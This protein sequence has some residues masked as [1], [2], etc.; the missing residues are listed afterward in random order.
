MKRF[1]FGAKNGI[2]IVDL[3]KTAQGLT[4]A[5]E[6]LKSVAAQGGAI[7][8]VGTKR[9]AQS[10]IAEEAVRCGHYYV[11]LRWLGG[12]LT[13][14]QT[15]RKSIERLKQI[16]AW[17]TDGTMEKLTKK[18]VSGL[19]KELAKLERAFQGIVLM[20]R[21]PKAIY[22]VDAK[23]EETAIQEANRLGIP[24]VALVDTNS[25]PDPIH[26]VIPGN[27]DAIRSIKLVTR[28]LADSIAEG[29]QAYLAGLE[30][31]A[32]K[33]RAA[34]EAKEAAQA[35]E[36]AAAAA[37]VPAEPAALPEPILDDVEAIIPDATLKTK[38]DVV[39]EAS[40]KKKAPKAKSS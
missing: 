30:A 3:E 31:E 20:G 28:L 24:V 37:A 14:F 26:Y 18:E 36:E 13:N 29:H 25:D 7:L 23:K 16:R 40:K 1:I 5:R 2:Y 11:N 8:F 34:E 15:I 19:E 21:L 10:I 32:A 38:V 4:K 33:V 12:L 6:F 35:A 27:D 17:R 22:L 9:Q 39:D